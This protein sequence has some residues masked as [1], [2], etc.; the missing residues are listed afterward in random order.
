MTHIIQ[1]PHLL[2]MTVIIKWKDTKCSVT[3]QFF[4]TVKPELSPTC[5]HPFLSLSWVHM[6][7]ANKLNLVV[8]QLA[9]LRTADCGVYGLVPGYFLASR[10]HC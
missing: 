1:L 8:L 9:L 6:H 5:L 10:G 2:L 7:N 3:R 4:Q